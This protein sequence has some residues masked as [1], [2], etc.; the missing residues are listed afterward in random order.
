M[1]TAASADPVDVPKPKKPGLL[2]RVIFLTIAVGCFYIMYSR[3]NGAAARE[4]M[5]LIPYM[6]EVFSHVAWVPWLALMIVYSCFYFLVDTRVT[7]S[8]LNWFVDDKIRYRDILPIRASAYIISLLSEQIGKGAMALYL[9]RRDGVPGWEVGSAMLFIMFGE[10][11]YL[12]AWAVI[13]FA[14]HAHSVDRPRRSD[15]AHALDS[16]LQRHDPSEQR[17]AEPADLPRLPAG[18]AVALR[19]VLPPPFAS[20]PWRMG[21]LHHCAEA[22]RR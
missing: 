16:L 1:T 7:T 3:L 20:A 10:V 18:Q 5:S 17:P 13:G 21:R 2:Q 12:M 15:C 8:V 11:F 22:L 4:G 14:V 19:G 6:R 9:N